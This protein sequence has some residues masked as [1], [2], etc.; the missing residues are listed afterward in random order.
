M[1]DFSILVY[2]FSILMY[3]VSLM[4]KYLLPFHTAEKSLPRQENAAGFLNVNE[5]QCV[6]HLI[7]ISNL[8]PMDK[9]CS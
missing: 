8:R 2:D 3:F 1:Y 6:S 4:P 5:R 9:H 7:M